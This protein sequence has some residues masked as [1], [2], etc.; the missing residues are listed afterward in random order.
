MIMLMR[1][2]AGSESV[3]RGASDG[4]SP[5]MVKIEGALI[6]LWYHGPK[7][8]HPALRKANDWKFMGHGDNDA[9]KSS[10]HW[11]EGPIVFNFPDDGQGSNAGS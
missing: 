2:E 11:A 9:V 7:S 3:I 8:L 6:R 4:P 10:C 5:L 1:R